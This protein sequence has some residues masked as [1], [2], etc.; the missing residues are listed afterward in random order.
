MYLNRRLVD[1]LRSKNV[2]LKDGQ[3]QVIIYLPNIHT[4]FKLKKKTIIQSVSIK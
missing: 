1:G 3:I 2:T 4:K